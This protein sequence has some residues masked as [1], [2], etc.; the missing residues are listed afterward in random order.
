M[1]LYQKQIDNGTNNYTKE[2]M[3]SENVKFLM[4]NV[5]TRKARVDQLQCTEKTPIPPMPLK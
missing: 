5:K 1:R 4:T 3:M 2:Q